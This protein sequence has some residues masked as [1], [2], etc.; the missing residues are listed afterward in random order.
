MLLFKCLYKYKPQIRADLGEDPIKGE[1]PSV[2][3]RLKN[4]NTLQKTLYK[5][6]KKATKRQK[7][8]HDKKRL[9]KQYN[10]KDL[11]TLLT[12]NLNLK[13]KKRK[14]T[15]KFIKPFYITSTVKR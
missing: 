7:F 8:Y 1:V 5:T 11:I 9:L 4:L 2:T 15:S 10:Q 14:L 13:G 3:K 6:Y 12:K